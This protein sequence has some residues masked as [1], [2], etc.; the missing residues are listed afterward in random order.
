MRPIHQITR[1]IRKFLNI[2]RLSGLK[3]FDFISFHFFLPNDVPVLIIVLPLDDFSTKQLFN[4]FLFQFL[5]NS[6]NYN[7]TIFLENNFF[8]KE[9]CPKENLLLIAFALYV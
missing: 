9:F 6:S 8:E 5:I 1:K 3:M 4:Y 2:S 7:E